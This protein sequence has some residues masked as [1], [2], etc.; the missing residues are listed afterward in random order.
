MKKNKIEGNVI[1]IIVQ[2]FF[3]GHIHMSYFGGH[4]YPCFEFLVMSR[5]GFKARLGSDLLKLR[6]KM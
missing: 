5:P 2:V 4:W 6:R 3:G 1:I